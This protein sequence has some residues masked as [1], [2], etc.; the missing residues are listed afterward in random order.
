[1]DEIEAISTVGFPIVAYLIA[2]LRIDAS[3]R[4]NTETLNRL[5]NAVEKLCNQH[6]GN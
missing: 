4:A 5:S 2:V 6:G 1:M 3:I